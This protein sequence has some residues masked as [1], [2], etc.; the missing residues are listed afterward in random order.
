[1]KA[2]R[3]FTVFFRR[4]L[5][6]GRPRARQRGAARWAVKNIFS[7]GGGASVASIHRTGILYDLSD[8]GIN[9]YNG[10]KWKYFIS[11]FG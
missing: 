9:N 2:F 10:V 4:K 7:N 6:Y 8:T 3:S 5:A 11:A 1:M